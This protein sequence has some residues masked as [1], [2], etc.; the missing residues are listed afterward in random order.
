VTARRIDRN[1]S[2]MIEWGLH[3]R[4]LTYTYFPQAPAGQVESDY[5]VPVSVHKQHSII[6]RDED[7]VGVRDETASP[8]PRKRSGLIEDDD[9][10]IPALKYVDAVLRIH[11]NLAHFV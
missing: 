8:G 5:L 9:G 3:S 11:C 4:S 2:R 10:R 1:I 7:A 6:F